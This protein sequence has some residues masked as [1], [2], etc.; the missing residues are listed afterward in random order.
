MLYNWYK[1]F[2]K[3]DFLNTGLVSRTYSLNLDGLGQKDILVTTGNVLG[4]TYEGTFLALTEGGK[5]PFAWEG[6]ALYINGDNDVF[7]GF[8]INE[9]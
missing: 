8:Q 9:N 5:N 6:L 3:T 7:L 1:I 4:V 2:N